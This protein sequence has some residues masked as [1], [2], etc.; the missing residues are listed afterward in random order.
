MKKAMLVFLSLSILICM[1]GCTLLPNI[2]NAVNSDLAGSVPQTEATTVPT[3]NQDKEAFDQKPMI[4]VSLQPVVETSNATDG[5]VLFNYKY[6][7][8]SLVVQ[9][10]EI[11]NTV[12]VDFLNRIDETA[13][14]ATE[15]ANAAKADY[16]PGT[17]WTPYLCQITYD[18]V[19]IDSS[20]LSLIGSYVCYSGSAHPETSHLSVNYNLITGEPLELDDILTGD[21]TSDKLSE[22]VIHSLETQSNNI[23]FYDGFQDTVKE[24]LSQGS[25]KETSWYFTENGLCFY[26]SPYEIA[27]YSDGLVVA[28]IPYSD[29][30]GILD[31]GFFPSEMETG[32]G[33][34]VASRFEENAPNEFTQIS[35]VIV[36][37]EAEKILLHTDSAVKHIKFETGS[38]NSTATEFTPE[39]TIFAAYSLTPGDAIMI[40]HT[41]Q[42]ALPNLRLTYTN[43]AGENAYY[44]VFDQN[45]NEP[46]LVK[47][48]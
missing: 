36:D 48:P 32:N 45:T 34:V 30:T 11:A 25:V 28:T 47:N 21:V 44:V 15:I 17:Q 39:H 37:K 42:D 20:I 2:D 46:Q 35:E 5:T 13:T 12:I 8:M 26:F 41:I 9:D 19:R 38:W 16:T 43:T 29:L 33:T 24:R 22:A 10:P 7:N 18:P 23:S 31:D 40:A 4:S 3:F 27:P 14:R 1:Q 6:Q